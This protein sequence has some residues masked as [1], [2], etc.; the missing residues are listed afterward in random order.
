MKLPINPKLLLLSVAIATLMASCS[1]M[2]KTQRPIARNGNGQTAEPTA[3]TVKKRGPY[4]METPDKEIATKYSTLMGVKKNDIKNGRLYN[5][6]EEWMGTP[7]RFGGLGK[8]GVDCSGFVYNLE[9]QVYDIANMPRSTNLQINFIK[10]KY[11]EELKEG[12]LVFFDFD[13][14]Q[15]SHVGVYLQNGYVVHASTRRGVIIVKL[16]DPSLYKYFSR[17]GSIILE[18][19]S[20]EQSSG[21]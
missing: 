9:Q 15:F 7:Y 12:D 20:E 4:I 18:G 14:K 1:S 10:R 11:E 13:G 8:D 5:F 19:D 16:H 17:G 2:K 3:P 6:I 21:R